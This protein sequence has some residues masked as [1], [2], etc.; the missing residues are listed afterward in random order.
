[1]CW[2]SRR[3]LDELAFV[4]LQSCWM[5]NVKD[6]SRLSSSVSLNENADFLPGCGGRHQRYRTRGF[7]RGN[8][9]WDTTGLCVWTQQVTLGNSIADLEDAFLTFSEDLEVVAIFSGYGTGF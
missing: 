7:G 4:Y 1:M 6:S 3:H 9:A 8:I 2:A 5:W